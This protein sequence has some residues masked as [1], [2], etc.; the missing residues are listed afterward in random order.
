MQDVFVF[1]KTGIGED[2]RVKGRFRPTGI[3]PKFFERLTVAGA[4][5]PTSLFQTVV[6]I[7]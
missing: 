4:K 3:R 7:R 6:E 5:L 1:D 2:G